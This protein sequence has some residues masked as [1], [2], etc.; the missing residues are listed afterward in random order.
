MISMSLC[1]WTSFPFSGLNCFRK[2]RGQKNCEIQLN[3]SGAPSVGNKLPRSAAHTTELWNWVSGACSKCCSIGLHYSCVQLFCSCVAEPAFDVASASPS[4]FYSWDNT[5][6][7]LGRKAHRSWP[8]PTTQ[9]VPLTEVWGIY[10]ITAT[11]HFSESPRL[12]QAGSSFSIS[13]GLSLTTC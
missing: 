5:A 11:I 10:R 4:Q 8:T 3:P 2:M 12:E 6:I 13:D 9:S 1:L 7:F